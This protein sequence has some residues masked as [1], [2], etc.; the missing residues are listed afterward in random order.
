MRE[1]NEFGRKIHVVALCYILSLVIPWIPTMIMVIFLYSALKNI[2]SV[3]FQ[4]ADRYLFE[5]RNKFIYAYVLRIFG[6]LLLTTGLI[7]LIFGFIYVGMEIALLN[8]I[9][10]IIGL[11]TIVLGSI[12]EMKAWDNLNMFFKV[13]RN[14]FPEIILRDAIYGTEKLRTGNLLMALSFL[15]V[16]AIIGWIFHVI[17]YFKLSALKHLVIPSSQQA[18]SQPLMKEPEQVTINNVVHGNTAR[19]CQQCGNEISRDTNYCFGCG[20]QLGELHVVKSNN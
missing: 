13:H 5:F 9:P 12:V 18:I 16:P 17:G 6:I 2:K 20:A 7:G 11:I 1:F 19:F 8:I 3:L 15:I 14:E 10:I 4:M